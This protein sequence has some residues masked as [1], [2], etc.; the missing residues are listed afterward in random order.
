[1]LREGIVDW[2]SRWKYACINA[3]ARHWSCGFFLEALYKLVM[4]VCISFSVE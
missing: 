1:M 2:F 3:S 4:A